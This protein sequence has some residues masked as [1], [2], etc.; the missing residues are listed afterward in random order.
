MKKALKILR[1]I[2]T[3]FLC[4][5]L[6]ILI[7]IQLIFT[8]IKVQNK[9]I[10]DLIDREAVLNLAVDNTLIKENQILHNIAI[11]YI[12]DYIDY[13]FY[14]RSY[15]TI[16]LGD[17]TGLD[18]FNNTNIEL[19]SLK[20]KFDIDYEKV[21]LIRDINNLISNQSIYLL[22]NIGI[23]AVYLIISILYRSFLKG[24][25]YF[26][27]SLILSSL[28]VLIISSILYTNLLN[29]AQIS[30]QIIKTVIDNIYMVSYQKI[31]VIYLVVGFMITT[32]STLIPK[33]L[34]K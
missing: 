9:K 34:K 13:V 19:D 21:V 1:S 12:D 16:N 26:G 24:F 15:P 6:I 11:K 17:A 2:I 8:I 28:I 32:I 27:I 5:I 22:L 3:S 4:I 31:S 29:G 25:K 7:T 23:F 20:E 10:P 30:T 33:L 18:I 14:K